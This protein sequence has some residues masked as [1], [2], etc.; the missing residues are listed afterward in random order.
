AVLRENKQGQVYGITFIDYRT[1]AVFNGSDIGK[2]Y[3]IAGI[4]GTLDSGQQGRGKALKPASET[5]KSKNFSKSPEPS[6]ATEA[7]PN[8]DGL[9]KELLEPEK[10]L[11][12]VPSELLKKKKKKRNPNPK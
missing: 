11:S 7:H 8:Q 2:P 1:K 5:S 10:N 9:F 12:R 4:R 6:P 3:S